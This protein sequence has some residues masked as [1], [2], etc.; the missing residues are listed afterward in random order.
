M[1][2]EFDQNDGA[3]NP[4]GDDGMPNTSDDSNDE[5]EEETPAAPAD[6]SS[7]DEGSM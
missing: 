6:D 1:T 4:A 3:M 2:N 7:E 5:A